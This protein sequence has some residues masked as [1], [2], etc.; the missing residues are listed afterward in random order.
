MVQSVPSVISLIQ[1][2]KS[3]TQ[4]IKLNTLTLKEITDRESSV[5]MTTQR[6]EESIISDP[7]IE[8]TQSFGQLNGIEMSSVSE[9]VS[10]VDFPSKMIQASMEQNSNLILIPI[11][12][13]QSNGGMG[14]LSF[15][16]PV[17]SEARCTVALF[18]DRGFGIG[19]SLD[20]S[21][22]EEHVAHKAYFTF[23]DHEDDQ[24]ALSLIS[25]MIQD[26]DFQVEIVSFTEKT[27]SK[28]EIMKGHPKVSI[29]YHLSGN[30]KSII[31]KEAENLKRTDLVILGKKTYHEVIQ[32][33]VDQISKASV[34]V[35]QK[36]APQ[37]TEFL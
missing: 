21:Q 5:L 34:L 13:A 8:V 28:L 30:A 12:V 26:P 33:W 15:W 17:F 35:V 24:E 20:A 32:T 4:K 27:N 37:Q 29:S 6:K 23:F 19:K 1:L 22:K 31:A 25:Y 2:F 11:T 16:A 36:H 10:K 7:M 18:L 14:E 9:I 3:S